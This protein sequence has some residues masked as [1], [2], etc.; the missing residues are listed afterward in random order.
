MDWGVPLLPLLPSRSVALALKPPRRRHR[1]LP[2][3]SESAA[4]SHAS[5]AAAGLV[6]RLGW[7]LQTTSGLTCDAPQTE[8][9]DPG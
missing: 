4:V 3:P 2:V 9:R 6:G 8:G 7:P 1:H 5:S